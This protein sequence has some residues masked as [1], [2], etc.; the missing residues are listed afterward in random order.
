MSWLFSR[1]L[2]EEFLA[3][4]C[5]DGEPSAPLNGSPTPQAFWSHDKTT[6]TSPHFPSGMTFKVLTAEVG[7]DLLMSFLEAFRAKT[8]AQQAEGLESMESEVECGEKWRGSFA[9]YDPDSSLWR[10]H[11]CSLL[12]G[13]DEYLGTWPQWGLMRNGESW[14][15]VMSGR[16]TIENAFGSTPNGETFFHTPNCSGL[17]G[18]SSSRKALKKRIA[19]WSTPQASDCRDRGNLSNPSVQRRIEIGKQV[20]LSMVVS[21]ESGALNPNWVEWL[22]GWP[23]GWTDLKPLGTDRFQRWRQLHGESSQERDAA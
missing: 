9:K 18:G 16:L 14:E 21:T 20:N 22:M 15:R 6:D 2:V 4:S 5:L 13:L 11:Q 10:T 19:Q 17:D 1:V 8:S 12:G 7:E 3:G 23:I